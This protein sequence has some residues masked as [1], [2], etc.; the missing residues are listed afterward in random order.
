MKSKKSDKSLTLEEKLEQALVPIEEQPYEV[1][2]NW[3][4]VRL[5]NINTYKGSQLDPSKYSNEEFELYSVPSFDSD[6]PEVVKGKEIKSSK[7][8]VEINDVLLCKIN[9]RI[10]RVW[11]V[12]GHTKNKL[13]ASSEWIIIRNS[14]INS[15]YFMYC[16][17]VQYFRQLMLSSVVGVGGSL[18][19]AQ[20]KNV[21]NYP[22]P[23]PPLP[24]QQRIVDLIE[25]LYA[26]LDEA[27][28]KVQTA[29]DSFELRKAAIL[30][31]AFTGELTKAWRLS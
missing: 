11:K 7:Q 1:P 16:L 17:R 25:R 9:P 20:P 21:K 4:W 26:K 18:T 28:E 2:P 10:N 19:R 5:K 22:I 27:K 23:L 6:Y 24:E 15:D 31:K 12:S 3:C 30:H 14:N 29:I 13:I 8:I